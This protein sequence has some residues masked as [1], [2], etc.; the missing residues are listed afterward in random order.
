MKRKNPYRIWR[1]VQRENAGSG[2]AGE[3]PAEGGFCSKPREGRRGFT[4]L[5]RGEGAEM[6]EV[7]TTCF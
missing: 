3:G 5:R 7:D 4:S 2:V 1:G 6:M